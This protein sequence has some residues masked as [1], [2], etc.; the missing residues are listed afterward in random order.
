M[1]L[2]GLVVAL[3]ACGAP[4]QA[5]G[6]TKA[7]TAACDT[8]PARALIAEGRLARGAAATRALQPTCPGDGALAQELARV[9]GELA[10]TGDPDKLVREAQK[11]RSAGDE[12]AARRLFDVALANAERRGGRA[13]I[14][15]A[16]AFISSWMQWSPDG[17]W[18]VLR[19]RGPDHWDGA[20]HLVNPTTGAHFYTERGGDSA[21]SPDGRYLAVKHRGKLE[22][23][24]LGSGTQVLADRGSVAAPQFASD[25][26][27][28]WGDLHDAQAIVYLR[29]LD[30]GSEVALRA[31]TIAPTAVGQQRRVFRIELDADGFIVTWSQADASDRMGTFQ[32]WKPSGNSFVLQ[33]TLEYASPYFRRMD[34]DGDRLV[35][36]ADEGS[37]LRLQLARRS[38]VVT[39][40]SSAHKVCGNGWTGSFTD[41][42]L[43]CDQTLVIARDRTG[44]QWDI[45]SGKLVRTWS[46]GEVTRASCDARK[47]KTERPTMRGMRPDHSARGSSPEPASVTDRDG[48]VSAR[49]AGQMTQLDN[50]KGFEVSVAPDHL[51]VFGVF[52]REGRG[53]A[54]IWD[55][56]GA[57]VWR[58]LEQPDPLAGVGFD[59]A[60]NLVAVHEN[61][62]IWHLALDPLALRT[63]A[64]IPNCRLYTFAVLPDDRVAFACDTN[65]EP[66]LNVHVRIEGDADTVFRLHYN[67]RAPAFAA[68]AQH[69]SAIAVD[70]K[71]MIRV[72]SL[73]DGKE[74]WSSRSTSYDLLSS[75]VTPSGERTVIDHYRQLSIRDASGKELATPS[76]A[77]RIYA[78]RDDGTAFVTG[79]RYP[80]SLDVRD[81]AGTII[82]TLAKARGAA[83]FGPGA[84]VAF[85]HLEQ[86]TLVVHDLAAHREHGVRRF[87]FMP[88][89][90]DHVTWS[91]DGSQLAALADAQLFVWGKDGALRAQILSTSGGFLVLG[92][93]GTLRT[94]GD[95]K[96]ARDLL[97]CRVGNW[98]YPLE[99]CEDR[100]VE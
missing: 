49:L 22:V 84:L 21:I 3:I 88:N 70:D 62:T 60:G 12:I 64:A 6:P 74:R 69:A 28:V 86:P 51:H 89:Q 57:V 10:A 23:F 98:I 65:V 100:L 92:P 8:A 76:N 31:P 59:S 72:W 82:E 97:A 81:M 78:L 40:F 79:E 66:P 47:F 24:D 45:A 95:G 73:P 61:T 68:S 1:R 30:T 56:T 18:A 42:P 13:Q 53:R 17:R 71:S 93:G 58:S 67:S 9:T 33:H 37:R 46:T 44:C 36:V 26:R 91:R 87:P 15:S 7:A 34:I 16:S 50:S 43:R 35:A 4:R 75:W 19:E 54:Q 2:V 96:R 63:T 41:P 39:S 77:A 94:L 90:V 5:P 14:V 52:D 20:I 48:T 99:L 38:G 55:A 29:D 25:G 27:L 11:A 32:I 80:E 85:P 83:A